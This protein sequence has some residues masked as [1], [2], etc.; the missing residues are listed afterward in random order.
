MDGYSDGWAGILADRLPALRRSATCLG[1]FRPAFGQGLRRHRAAVL[2]LGFLGVHR[3][4]VGKIGTGILMLLTFGG[5]GIWA[6]IDFIM[7]VLGS[8][9]DSDGLKITNR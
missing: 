8:F 2:F 9:T 6:L 3:F 4:Y 1:R 5:F 7:V